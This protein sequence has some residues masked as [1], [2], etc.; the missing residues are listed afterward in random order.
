M[1]QKI[2]HPCCIV[3]FQ[4]NQNNNNLVENYFKNVSKCDYMIKAKK[5]IKEEVSFLLINM[6][7]RDHQLLTLCNFF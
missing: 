2:I 3:Y 1:K 5:T 6:M 4:E 7:V